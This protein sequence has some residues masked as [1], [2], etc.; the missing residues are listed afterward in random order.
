M[1]EHGRL[2]EAMCEAVRKKRLR[3]PDLKENDG[4]VE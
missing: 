1:R 4:E 3:Y 2:G